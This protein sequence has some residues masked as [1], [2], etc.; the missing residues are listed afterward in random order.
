MKS[1][2]SIIMVLFLF[3]AMSVSAQGTKDAHKDTKQSIKVECKKDKTK[4]TCTNMKKCSMKDSTKK[5]FPM[6]K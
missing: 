3:T 2:M 1:I 4:K 5:D 6:K